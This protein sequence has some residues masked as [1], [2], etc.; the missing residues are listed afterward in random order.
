MNTSKNFDLSSTIAIENAA[1]AA[2][3]GES[4]SKAQT[5]AL[6]A[7]VVA[8]CPTDK[9]GQIHWLNNKLPAL[10]RGW[11]SKR[12]DDGALVVA[13][14]DATRSARKRLVAC[15]KAE[16]E[17]HIDLGFSFIGKSKKVSDGVN[18]TVYEWISTEDAE[19]LADKKEKT[20]A[21]RKKEKEQEQVRKETAAISAAVSKALERTVPK[22][23]YDKLQKSI[24]SP[25]TADKQTALAQLSAWARAANKHGCTLSEIQYALSALADLVK[26]SAKEPAKPAKPK[27]AKN[28]DT[29]LA[30]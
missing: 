17:G 15:V 13:N 7:A 26:V 28:R 29:L 30:V 2:S 11:D 27:A 14:D 24:V 8:I 12:G 20:A 23:D 18:V 10:V 9:E 22:S 3:T 21:T 25:Q 4:Q 6:I 16:V 5:E 1:I 19:A